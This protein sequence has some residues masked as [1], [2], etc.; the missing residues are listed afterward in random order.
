[1]SM[2]I[3]IR[4]EHGRALSKVENVVIFPSNASTVTTDHGSFDVNEIAVD[5]TT[6][7]INI[8]TEA[9]TI[10]RVWE[11]ETNQ[12]GVYLESK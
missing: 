12:Y 10:N 7:E 4:D 11:G 3:V 2:T 1:M 8:Y 6:N 9:Y 5:Y